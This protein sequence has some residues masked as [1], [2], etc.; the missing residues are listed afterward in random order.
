MSIV[1]WWR[2]RGKQYGL[3]RDGRGKVA[4]IFAASLPSDKGITWEEA[5]R[6]FAAVSAATRPVL[7]PFTL[8]YRHEEG[9]AIPLYGGNGG[10]V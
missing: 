1:T 7:T 5:V 9:N 2:L 4:G 10:P 3:Y 6:L 8:P